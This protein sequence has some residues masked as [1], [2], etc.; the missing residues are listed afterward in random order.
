M[1]NGGV[2]GYGPAGEMAERYM[3]DVNLDALANQAT[4]LQSHRGGTGEVRFVSVDIMDDAGQPTGLIAAGDTIVVRAIYRA[5]QRVARPVFQV[6]IIDVDTGLVVTTGSS[7]AAAMPNEVSGTGAIECRF[8]RLPLR[9]RQ[10]VLRLSIA[11]SDQLASYDVVTA[12]PRFAVTGQGHGIDGLADEEDGLVSLPFE[13]VHHG[14]IE[15]V[16]SR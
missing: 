11:D 16:T 1:E 15:G 7:R 4:A 3:N 2:R 13:F 14:A 5:E 8:T 10:Y 9:P 6:A 12:G